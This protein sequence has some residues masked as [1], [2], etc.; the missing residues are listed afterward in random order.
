MLRQIGGEE[1]NIK[2]KIKLRADKNCMPKEKL[3]QE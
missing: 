1:L 2:I 3:K